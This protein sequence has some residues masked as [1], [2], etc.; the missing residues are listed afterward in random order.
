MSSVSENESVH[1][2]GG[3][4]FGDDI[5]STLRCVCEI[6]I[7]HILVSSCCYY[8]CYVNSIDFLEPISH[9][10]LSKRKSCKCFAIE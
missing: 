5:R 7:P 2:D 9:Y 1:G 4:S 3:S 6:S 8:Y 10:S